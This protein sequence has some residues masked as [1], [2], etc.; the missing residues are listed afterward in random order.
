MI[1]FPLHKFES[2]SSEKLPAG[3]RTSRKSQR[4][5]GRQNAS[6]C[7]WEKRRK[8]FRMV[9]SPRKRSNPQQRMQDVVGAQPFTVGK[10]AGTH[11]HGHQERRERMGQRNRVVGSRFSKGQL[12]LDLA[13]KLVQPQK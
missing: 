12:A 9:S 10:P 13:G 2:R 1:I 7:A 6:M 5:S 3:H 11:H 8:N 4:Q